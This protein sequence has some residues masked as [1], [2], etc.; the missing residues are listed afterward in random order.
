MALLISIIACNNPEEAI[1]ENPELYFDLELFVDD[2]IKTGKVNFDVTKKVTL[3]GKEE[4][5]ELKNYNINLELELLKKFN[6]NKPSLGGKYEVTEDT[7]GGEDVT[8]YTAIEDDLRTEK[9]EVRRSENEVVYIKVEA[10]Q[11]SILSD[12]KQSVIFAPEKSYHLISEDN[13]RFSKVLKKEILI[14]F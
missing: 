1:N 7:D 11:K 6:I 14:T 9:L 5:Q 12:N 10:D 3:N 2:Y 13:N 8:I 4:I